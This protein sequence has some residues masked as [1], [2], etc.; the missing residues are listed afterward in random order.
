M[1]SS[2]DVE[3]TV[4]LPGEEICWNTETECPTLQKINDRLLFMDNITAMSN[5]IE[6]KSWKTIATINFPAFS[7]RTKSEKD[8]I[9][10]KIQKSNIHILAIGIAS[11]YDPTYIQELKNILPQLKFNELHI[12]L[13]SEPENI[14]ELFDTITWKKDKNF[15]LSLEFIQADLPEKINLFNYVYMAQKMIQRNNNDTPIASLS[16]E[17]NPLFWEFQDLYKYV[18]YPEEWGVLNTLSTKELYI[19]DI[20]TTYKNKTSWEYEDQKG[21]T[22]NFL[23]NNPIQ[24]IFI[25]SIAQKQ[26]WVIT[27]STY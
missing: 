7:D 14:I 24:N 3:H 13:Y 4:L 21:R 6:T 8:E 11:R 23:K 18:L 16:I 12:Q 19:V 15:K 22:F 20:H 17:F 2:G 1:T 26:N 5:S 10:K 27:L 25:D 9:I